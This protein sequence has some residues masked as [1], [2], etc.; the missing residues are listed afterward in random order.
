MH[1]NDG[2]C[3]EEGCRCTHF[4]GQPYF[5]REYS[6]QLLAL[7]LKGLRPEK[8]RDNLGLSQEEIDAILEK[9]IAELAEA[10]VNQITRNGTI[11]PPGPAPQGSPPSDSSS[12]SATAGGPALGQGSLDPSTFYSDAPP[13]LPD[14][15]PEQGPAN[16]P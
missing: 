9:R 13:L 3:R 11:H 14:G 5:E 6:D 16:G 1:E 2:V 12:T 10:R 15:F 7:L 8:F 4:L